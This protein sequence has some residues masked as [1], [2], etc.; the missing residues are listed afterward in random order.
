[1]GRETP[2]SGPHFQVRFDKSHNR[3]SDVEIISNDVSGPTESTDHRGLAAA[4]LSRVRNHAS[5]LA[6]HLRS[7]SDDLDRRESELNS[8]E[9]GAESDMRGLRLSIE[10]E[11]HQLRERSERLDAQEQ[12]LRKSLKTLLMLVDNDGTSTNPDL[13]SPDNTEPLERQL[14]RATTALLRQQK[15]R[16]AKEAVLAR[17]GKQTKTTTDQLCDD[18]VQEQGKLQHQW[19]ERETALQRRAAAIDSRQTDLDASHLTIMNA[20]QETLDLLLAAERLCCQLSQRSPEPETAHQLETIG[21]QLITRYESAQEDLLRQKAQLE[22]A[23]ERLKQRYIDVTDQRQH[24]EKDL[25]EQ[26]LTIEQRE[27]MLAVQ[28]QQLEQQQR[29]HALQAELWKQEKRMF[30]QQISELTSGQRQTSSQMGCTK[31]SDNKEP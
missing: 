18:C 25:A 12:S 1:M 13:K 20:S 16:Q 29:E 15:E 31:T 30:Q 9:A 14:D 19:V 26:L 11:Q 24:L 27:A 5:Q 17:N 22:E 23:E 2:Q 7:L 10:S 3:G 4:T 6:S 8:R 28:E 21:H